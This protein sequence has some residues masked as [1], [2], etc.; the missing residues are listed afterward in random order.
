MKEESQNKVGRPTKYK[1]EFSDQARKLCLLGATDNELAD[2]F[3]VSEV[4]INAWKK[5]FPEFLKSIKSGKINADSEVAD[6]LFK[7]AIGYQYKELKEEY[8]PSEIL[9]TKTETTKTVTPEVTA[10][11]FW[12]KN[13]QPE[14]WRDKQNI[15][16]E[17]KGNVNIPIHKWLSNNNEHSNSE[18]E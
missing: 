12:L 3:E 13:R 9:K 10:Q 5:E 8:G 2:F 16:A 6:R 7:R 18:E 1:K 15:E 11:I 4:T 17:I 14:K